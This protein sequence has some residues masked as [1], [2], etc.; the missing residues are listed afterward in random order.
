[1]RDKISHHYFEI[2]T[3]V[4]FR[5]IEEDIPQMKPVCVH[6]NKRSRLQRYIELVALSV[7]SL[8]RELRFGWLYAKRWLDSYRHPSFPAFSDKA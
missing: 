3:D 6:P 5:T 8:H 2:D 7:K 1:M 4:V